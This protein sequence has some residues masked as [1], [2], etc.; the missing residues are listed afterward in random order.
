M[1]AVDAASLTYPEVQTLYVTAALAETEHATGKA[2]AYLCHLG[3]GVKHSEAW[4]RATLDTARS[5]RAA[6]QARAEVNALCTFIRLQELNTP[7][8]DGGAP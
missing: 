8:Q 4:Q 3:D 6:V 2:V 7:Q 1:T 5:E